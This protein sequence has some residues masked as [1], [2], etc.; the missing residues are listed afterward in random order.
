MFQILLRRG[1][2]FFI[3]RKLVLILIGLLAVVTFIRTAEDSL[4][5]EERTEAVQVSREDIPLAP[6]QK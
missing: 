4:K 6:L 5:A 1:D 2:L 3:M